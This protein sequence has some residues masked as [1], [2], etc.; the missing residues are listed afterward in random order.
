MLSFGF[1]CCSAIAAGFFFIF[2]FHSIPLYVSYWYDGGVHA[3]LKFNILYL[4]NEQIGW[5]KIRART[6]RHLNVYIN[7]LASKNTVHFVE[8]IRER[9]KKRFCLR[10]MLTHRK[11]DIVVKVKLRF[12]AKWNRLINSEINKMKCVFR[13][14][15]QMI[16]Y[17]MIWNGFNRNSLQNTIYIQILAH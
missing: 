13:T 4:F 10:A 15:L 7:F 14:F 9:E 17:D 3:L 11:I 6:H 8:F 2:F 1:C 16:W 12:L 5:Q